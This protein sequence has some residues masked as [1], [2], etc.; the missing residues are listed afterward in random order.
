MKVL[1]AIQGTGNGHLARAQDVIQILKQKASVDILISGTQTDLNL[2]YPIKY[3]LHGLSFV[4]GK[5]GGVDI[6]HTIKNLNFKIL[7]KEICQLPVENYDLVINDFEPIS[8]WACKFKK[9]NCFS[10]SHQSGIL[11]KKIPKPHTFDYIGHL[12]LKYYAPTLHRFSFHFSN[13]DE[14]TFTPIIRQEVRAIKKEDLG[15]YTVYLPS[16][17][18]EKLIETLS[19]FKNIKWQIFSKHNKSAFIHENIEIYP[20][21]KTHFT[22]SFSK[23]TGIICGAGFETPAEAL[24]LGKKLLVIPMKRQLEQLYNAA[25]LKKIGVSVINKLSLKNYNKILDWL[26][27]DHH[28]KIDY[29][30]NT[31]EIINKLFFY[32]NNM[33][34]PL[35]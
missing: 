31:E 6:W 32:Y 29:P 30:N 17:S 18:D 27:N 24:Y 23:C 21:S 3:R 5:K 13:Y 1:Y 25:A 26:N 14:Q 34:K 19:R 2:D 11:S 22:E 10:L 8:A 20:V 15:H 7:Y 33:N 9:V 12:I 4:F 35:P 28:I 16:Y